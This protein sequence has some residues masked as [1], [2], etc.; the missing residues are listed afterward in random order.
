MCVYVIDIMRERNRETH[1][2]VSLF[3]FSGSL[4]KLK[5]GLRSGYDCCGVGMLP[6]VLLRMS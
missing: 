2:Q 5:E 6:V 1:M 3:R 4:D